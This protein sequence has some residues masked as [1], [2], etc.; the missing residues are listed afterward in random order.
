MGFPQ[1]VREEALL[2]CKRHCAWCEQ[3]QGITIECHHIVPQ[4][5]GGDDSFDN[6]IPLCLNCHGKVGSYNSKHP[7]GTKISPNELKKRRDML[8]EM[9]K[10]NQILAQNVHTCIPTIPNKYDVALFEKIQEVFSEPNLEYYLTGFD[11]GKDFDKEIFNPLWR[12]IEMMKN[13]VFVFIDTELEALKQA[14]VEVVYDFNVYRATNTI[15]T[16]L[17][18]QTLI[19][20]ENLNYYHKKSK[21]KKGKF[22]DL[23]SGI[24]YA[25]EECRKMADEFNGLATKVWNALTAT[26][27]FISFF[28]S[29][30][31][32]LGSVYLQKSTLPHLSHS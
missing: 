26:P 30:R 2:A 5:E 7:R 29:G 10:R 19:C 11:L 6:C 31:Y 15:Q 22:N 1:S 9:V 12:F 27:H 20:W 14:L 21:K 32:G 13:S 3:S 4:S 18:T 16:S 25:L 24:Y 8:Y 23:E 17:G 28:L